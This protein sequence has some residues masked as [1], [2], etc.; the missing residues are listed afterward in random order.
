M[1]WVSGCLLLARWLPDDRARLA[2]PSRLAE[3]Q[4]R[5]APWDAQCPTPGGQTDVWGWSHASS[6]SQPGRDRFDLRCRQTTMA[7]PRV[8][9]AWGRRS[10]IAHHCR[11]L[12]H[13][14]ATDTG[15]VQGE[16]TSD[17]KLVLRLMAS[18][19]LLDML[20]MVGNGRV[21]TEYMLCSPTP[22]WRRLDSELPREMDFQGTFLW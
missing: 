17:G 9:R 6:S 11:L 8:I 22:D 21:P 7:A 2:V 18:L 14:L 1:L 12:T 3:A 13:L 10:G 4:Q 5:A 16:D 20:R 19:V 15:Q